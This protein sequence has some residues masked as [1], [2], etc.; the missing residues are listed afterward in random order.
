MR[1]ENCPALSPFRASRRLPGGTRRSETAAAACIIVSFRSATRCIWSNF[2]DRLRSKTACV[3]ASA[4]LRIIC[5]TYQI[6]HCKSRKYRRIG[7]GWGADK[8]DGRLALVEWQLRRLML[9]LLSAQPANR[10]MLSASRNEKHKLAI[11]IPKFCFLCNLLAEP[12][13]YAFNTK[14]KLMREKHPSP[15]GRKTS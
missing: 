8:G 3:S 1:T 15:F 2:L 5:D 12:P 11:D 9:I 13:T 4:K 14:R 7:E 10:L 6:S